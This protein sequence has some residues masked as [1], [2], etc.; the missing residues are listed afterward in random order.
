MT[1]TS[2]ETIMT[3]LL[4]LI[5]GSASYTTVTRQFKMW[6]DVPQGE[7]PWLC[8]REPS[9]AYRLQGQGIPPIRTFTVEF[10]IYTWAKGIPN[11]ITLLNPLLDAI[12]AVLAPDP[13]TGKQTL[14][15][16]SNGLP[17]VQ[18]VW[19]EGE[20]FKDDGALDG[21]GIARIPMKILVP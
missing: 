17:L 21:D 10:W 13:M 11:P 5:G 15:R 19:I 6:A 16:D 20:V 2:R 14:G 18:N 9:D 12:D 1:A 7:R 8:L 4:A 3:T